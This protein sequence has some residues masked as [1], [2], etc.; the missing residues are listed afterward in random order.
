MPLEAITAPKVRTMM[1]DPAR[2]RRSDPGNPEVC[3]VFDLHKIFTPEADRDYVATG[4]RTAG[5]GC[6][7]C[8]KVMIRRVIDDLAP[9]REKRSLYENKPEDVEA[10]LAEGTQSARQNASETMAE[11]RETLGL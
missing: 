10:V 6:L 1:T 4:C 8:K 5:I 2:K 9:V 11:V 7:E 3:P